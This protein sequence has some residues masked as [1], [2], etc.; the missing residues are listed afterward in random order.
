MNAFGK[1]LILTG[2]FMILTGGALLLISNIGIGKLPG[3]IV[4]KKG[5]FVF[6]FPLATGLLLSL[7][8]TLIFNIIRR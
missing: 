7:L 3:D 6:Y 2:L 1:I 4:V 5:N 8:L